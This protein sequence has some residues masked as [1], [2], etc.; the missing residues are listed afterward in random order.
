[1]SSVQ[2]RF[3][4]TLSRM[5]SVLEQRLRREADALERE[6]AAQRRADAT[7]AREDADRCREIGELYDPA[8]AAFGTQ[9]PQPVDD[10]RPGRYRRRLVQQAA[11]Q[12]AGLA[13]PRGD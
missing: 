8:F 4:A 10:E 6:D 7:R 1:M 13:R 11:G 12:I 2:A 5:D 3:D 9:T